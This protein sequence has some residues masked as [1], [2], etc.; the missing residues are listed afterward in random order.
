MSTWRAAVAVARKFASR[1]LI[2]LLVQQRDNASGADRLART[3]FL[4]TSAK[5]P[6]QCAGG[7]VWV[8]EAERRTCNR[9]ASVLAPRRRES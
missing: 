7:N 9:V 8:S 4:H 3:C 5:S 2:A 1:S 6:S